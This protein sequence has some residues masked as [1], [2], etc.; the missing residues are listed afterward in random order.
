MTRPNRYP[1]LALGVPL[2]LLLLFT[3]GPTIILLSGGALGGALGCQL[4]INGPVGPCLFM[5]HDLASSLS[6]ATAFGYVAFF[7]IPTGTSLLG[8][9]L[10][11]AVIVTLVWTGRRRR[12]LG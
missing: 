11:V 5:G 12:R 8:I 7:T 6:V 9:W 3:F 10:V 4:P 2:V 1:F